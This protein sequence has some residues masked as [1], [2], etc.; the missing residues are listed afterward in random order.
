MH[1]SAPLVKA[2]SELL[3]NGLVPSGRYCCCLA[4]IVFNAKGPNDAVS[5]D[6]TPT[7]T[8]LS[9]GTAFQELPRIVLFP[10]NSSSDYSRLYR[11][12]NVLYQ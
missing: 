7:S 3:K 6:T 9:S 4:L 12:E 10:R 2:S 11:D 1:F 8:F 5:I